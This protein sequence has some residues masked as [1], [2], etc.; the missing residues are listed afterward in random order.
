MS[1]RRTSID[2]L[3]EARK[4]GR[5]TIGKGKPLNSQGD[6][7]DLTFR[8]TS[9]GLKLYIKA[10]GKWNGV[11]VG[12]S[13]DDLEKSLNNLQKIVSTI[14]KFRLP[15]TYSVNGD[16]VLD[17][18]S[19]V[20]KFY[21]GGDTDDYAQLSVGGNGILTLRTFDSDGTAGNI[22]LDADGDIELNADGG[23]INFKDGSI[24]LG[25]I[26]YDTSGV[27]PA[28]KFVLYNPQ[29]DGDLL[30]IRAT[31]AGD[32]MIATNDDAGTNAHLTI[33]PDGDLKLQSDIKITAAKK[34]Y[35]DGGTHTYI[36][37]TLDDVVG[38][39]VGNDALMTL[40]EYGNAGNEVVFKTS[41]ATFSRAEATFSTTGVIG[42]GGTDDTDVDFRHSNKY[43]L[44]M[45]GD[46]T[47]VNLIFPKGSGNFTL[48]C[49]T[50]GDHDVSNWKVW[51][52]DE[53]AATTTDVMW[54]GGSVPAFTSSGVDICSFYWDATEQQCYGVCSLAFA[55]P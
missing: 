39:H 36:S 20:I 52:S 18:G 33:N 48:V 27:S 23:D 34:L 25:A 5:P 50:N 2:R 22:T 40:S 3:N 1:I 49:T 44:E 12:E 51:E 19:G 9:D 10:A 53:S 28:T 54:A 17:P 24:N 6:D 30:S 31:A 35:L 42:S 45:T 14:K 29:D 43:R 15:N 47:T 4:S 16:L 46:I 21:R 26:I 8:R 32:T 55:T 38:I 11:K 13:F 41:C 37:E 7:G